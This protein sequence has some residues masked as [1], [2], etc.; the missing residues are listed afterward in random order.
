LATSKKICQVKKEFISNNLTQFTCQVFFFGFFL[1]RIQADILGDQSLPSKFP[2]EPSRH[3]LYFI[4]FGTLVIANVFFIT[5][6][7]I[8][9]FA[10][11]I[12]NT[13]ANNGSIV[14]WKLLIAPIWGHQSDTRVLML[15]A[16]QFDARFERE[17]PNH[18]QITSEH[19]YKL[20]QNHYSQQLEVQYLYVIKKYKMNNKSNFSIFLKKI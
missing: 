7:T 5:G 15:E 13:S 17:W 12:W 16:W 6:D 20:C 14:G 11:R 18:K 1:Q 19:K 8:R 4:K 2:I 10:M 3:L 9:W